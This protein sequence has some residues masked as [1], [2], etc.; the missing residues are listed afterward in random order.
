M[1]D[2][3]KLEVEIAKVD[4]SGMILNMNILETIDGGVRGSFIVKDNINFYDTFIGHVQPEVKIKIRYIGTSCINSFIGDGVSDMSITKLGKEYTVHFISWPTMNLSINQLCEVYS[5][6]SDQILTKLWLETNGNNLP[7]SIETQAITKGKYVVPNINAGKAIKNVVDNAYDENYSAF[8][9]YQRLWDN[10][11]TRFQSLYD[12]DK[13][14]FYQ[15][16]YLGVLGSS[17]SKFKIQHTIAS[18]ADNLSSLNTVGTSSHFVL[19]D[20]NRGYSR[21]IGMGFYG[22]KISQIK[23]DQTTVTDLEPTDI[24]DIHSTAYK[25]S[26][27]LYDNN[28]KSLF[29]NMVDPVCQSAKGQKKRMFNQF[30]R[31][32]DVVSVPFLGV[33]FSIEVD[34][35]G[36]NISKSRMDNRFVVAQINHK[37]Y[38]NDGKMQYSQDLGLIRE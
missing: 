29:S 25:I 21:K 5:G 14:Y 30:M 4:L 8:C 22:K 16:E 26:E 33:G 17:M 38:L 10:G 28:T 11:I 13:N 34:T 2:L 1:L 23:L 3:Y 27:S 18:S 12:M 37:F 15:E 31:V 24:T 9:L 6:T 20:S 32:K 7:L 19:E 36:S 35:G